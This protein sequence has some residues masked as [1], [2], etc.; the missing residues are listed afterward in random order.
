[1]QADLSLRWANMVEGTFS[2]VEAHLHLIC[3]FMSSC[4][5]HL[6]TSGNSMLFR[7]GRCKEVAL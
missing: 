3:T 5:S 7:S 1:M 4:N 2:H 6:S